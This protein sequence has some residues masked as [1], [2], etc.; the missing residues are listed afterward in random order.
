MAI[1]TGYIEVALVFW[2]GYSHC[3]ALEVVINLWQKLLPDDV[4][5][6]RIPGFFCPNLWQTHAQLYY[7]VRDSGLP[8]R[9]HAQTFSEVHNR[10]NPLEDSGQMAV[11][12]HREFAIELV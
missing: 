1:D 10:Q 7:T 6:T 5:L 12:W 8:E 3:Y 4:Q 2:Y 9:T 11:F